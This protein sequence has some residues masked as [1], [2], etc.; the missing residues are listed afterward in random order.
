M[1]I[2]KEEWE[3][4]IVSESK[5]MGVDLRKIIDGIHNTLSE[6]KQESKNE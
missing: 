5:R 3:E 2:T 6:S 4:I 1:K